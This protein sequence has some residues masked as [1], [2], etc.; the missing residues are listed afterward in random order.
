MTNKKYFKYLLILTLRKRF[1]RIP[2]TKP[3]STEIII[4]KIIII[5]LNIWR[6]PESIDLINENIIANNKITPKSERHNTP[7]DVE[8][9]F[10]LALSSFIT[11]MADAGDLATK[12]EAHNRDKYIL[13]SNWILSKKPKVLNAKKTRIKPTEKVISILLNVFHF[14]L[15]KVPLISLKKSSDPA[16]K[17]I[18]PS[19]KSNMNSISFITVLLIKLKTLGP[20]NTPTTIKPVTRG[21]P[22]FLSWE[23][24]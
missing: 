22:N 19:D 7:I 17:A 1:K 6:E 15:L 10:P 20:I 3:I 11:A 13:I 4:S 18:K 5:I 12:I 21:R 24:R 16:A 2:Y 23:L 9:N 14:I 8:V